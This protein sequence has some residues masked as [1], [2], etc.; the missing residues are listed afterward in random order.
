VE[1]LK[2]LREEM[3]VVVEIVAMTE[4]VVVVMTDVDQESVEDN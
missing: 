2:L 4:E 1:R 3:L